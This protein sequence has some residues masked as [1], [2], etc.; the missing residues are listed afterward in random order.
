[1]VLVKTLLLLMLSTTI[2]AQDNVIFKKAKR[3]FNQGK[4]RRSL[5]ILKKRYNIKSTKTP[6][7]ALLLAGYNFEKMERWKNAGKIYKA[8]INS[9]FKSSHKKV[10]RAYNVLNKREDDLPQLPNKLYLY[11]HRLAEVYSQLYVKNFDKMG[12]ERAAHY[13]SR[14]LMLF[15]IS[16]NSDDYDGDGLEDIPTRFD[17]F[18]QLKKDLIYKSGWFVSSGY[19]SLKD[20]LSVTPAGD[21][22]SDIESTNEGWCLGGGYKVENAFWQWNLNGCYSTTVA[23]VGSTA[24]NFFEKEVPIT[25]IMLGPAALW[26]PLSGDVALGLNL[27]IIY[28]FG[29]Q[30][31]SSNFALDGEQVFSYGFLL[32][33]QWK[34]NQWDWVS[35]FGRFSKF[36]SSTW[37]LQI[38]YNL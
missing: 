4:Y 19:L 38:N 20:K 23:N 28:R 6:S 30:S 1:M 13:R 35:K 18:D 10:M 3:A 37:I 5:K 8:L 16:D 9:R 34:Y 24:I 7:G 17:E 15:H 31:N 25:V 22:S 21:K 12:K 33:F 26:K 2:F 32:E 36:A 14:A 11:Y 27:P 29:Y